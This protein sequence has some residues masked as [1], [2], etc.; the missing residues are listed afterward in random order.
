MLWDRTEEIKIQRSNTVSFINADPLVVVLIPRIRTIVKGSAKLVDDTPRAPQTMKLIVQSAAGG[1]IEQHTG[2]G[3]ERRTDF[4][5]LGA[6]DSQGDIGDHWR[7]ASG[8]WW[9]ITAIVPDN[10]YERRYVV[11]S[12]GKHPVG[13]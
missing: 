7:D 13:G 12:Y 11:E 2:D 9:E 5:L 1:S 10:G 4:Q 3:T 8:Q 6:W